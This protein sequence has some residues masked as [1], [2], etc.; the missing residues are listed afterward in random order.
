MLR[1]M[2][3]IACSSDAESDTAFAYSSSFKRLNARTHFAQASIV[4]CA[5][6]VLC[7]DK[8]STPTAYTAPDTVMLRKAT[9]DAIRLY[10]RRQ[11]KNPRISSPVF[12]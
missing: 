4:V 1:A 6:P 12:M 2:D 9:T 3:A 5:K 11:C 10:C 7:R 8:L